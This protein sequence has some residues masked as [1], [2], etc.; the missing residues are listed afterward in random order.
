V[1]WRLR[2]GIAAG[3]VAVAAVGFVAGML[4]QGTPSA[5]SIGEVEV[6]GSTATAKHDLSW[7]PGRA[8]RRLDLNVGS[9]SCERALHVVA[10]FS[11]HVLIS[12]LSGPRGYLFPDDGWTCWAKPQ[13]KQHGGG[14]QNF[15]LQNGSAIVYF[16]LMGASKGLDLGLPP[17]RICRSSDLRLTP[18][19]GAALGSYG[20]TWK[21]VNASATACR[22]DKGLS[23][24]VIEPKG[25]VVVRGMPNRT[26]GPPTLAL[27]PHE[28]ATAVVLWGN[29]CGPRS[30]TFRIEI[31]LPNAGGTLSTRAPGWATCT[32]P[33]STPSRI[34]VSDVRR[35][36]IG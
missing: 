5:N 3:V 15:C 19:W 23:A 7:C 28:I 2:I 9:I 36:T 32:G 29:W 33:A 20:G 30:G 35:A 14:V 11:Q 13:F 26:S 31:V 21:F 34:S 10:G 4:Q 24:R 27:Q 8:A 12:Y 16:Q 6:A 17:H 18:R 22:L 1:Q 25:K